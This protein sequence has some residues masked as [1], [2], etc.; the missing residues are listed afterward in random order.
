MSTA[1]KLQ[2]ITS[3]ITAIRGAQKL[4]NNEINTSDDTL[5]GIKLGNEYA[6]LGACITQLL[7]AQNMTDDAVFE[8]AIS[9]LKSKTSGLTV[10]EDH[11][12]EIITDANTANQVV[13]YIQDAVSIIA[14][15]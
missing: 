14:K 9:V 6:E 12:K 1:P 13:S 5:V 7:H 11:I 3:A 8:S 15:L 4:I 2:S 10:E